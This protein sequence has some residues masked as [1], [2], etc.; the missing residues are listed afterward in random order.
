MGI[1]KKEIINI[2]YCFDN[3]TNANYYKYCVTT[4]CQMIS[5]FS[6]N[7]N[8]HI[9]I[10]TNKSFNV[11][12][13]PYILNGIKKKNNIEI[14]QINID[15]AKFSNENLTTRWTIG[16]YFR[17]LLPI[18]L[19]NVDRILYFDSDIFFNVDAKEMW[20]LFDNHYHVQ[21][22]FD[23]ACVDDVLQDYF[24]NAKI[25][26]KNKR[27]YICSG[28]AIMNLKKIRKDNLCSVMMKQASK[29]NV[30][31]D[32]TIINE[33]CKCGVLPQEFGTMMEWKGWYWKRFKN[34]PPPSFALSGYKIPTFSHHKVSIAHWLPLWNIKGPRSEKKARKTWWKLYH[35]IFNEYPYKR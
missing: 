1:Q 31:H 27:C 20:D 19:K 34:N 24:N 23:T 14:T 26:F 21:G 8:Y 12:L 10:L 5:K 28:C 16:S 7:N 32:Q 3:L 35:N 18:L 2:A 11:D 33:Y 9:Y 6:N 4:I 13:K 15:E 22:A 30:Q 17:L 29:W 25:D